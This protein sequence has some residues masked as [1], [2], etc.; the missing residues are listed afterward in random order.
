[1]TAS[2][3]TPCAPPGKTQRTMPTRRR[4]WRTNRAFRSTA[5]IIALRSSRPSSTDGSRTSDRPQRAGAWLDT[6]TWNSCREDALTV[7]L[8]G[9]FDGVLLGGLLMYLDRAEAGVPLARL[10]QLAPDARLIVRESGVRSGVRSGVEVETGEYQVVWRLLRATSPVTLEM[11]PRALDA[12]G[13]E[14]PHLVNNFLL[15]ER[16]QRSSRP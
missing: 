12:V 5:S 4:T 9:E 13:V 6:T 1:M 10:G 14:W 16:D 3:T 2:T 15:L 7:P 8:Q 11:V